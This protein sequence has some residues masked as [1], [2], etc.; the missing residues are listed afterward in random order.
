MH[1]W[2]G[3]QIPKC[4]WVKVRV[5]KIA[6]LQKR[7]S[8][9]MQFLAKQLIIG[10]SPI[11]LHLRR[12]KVWNSFWNMW[13]LP[14]DQQKG[15]WGG[16]RRKCESKMASKRENG[17]FLPP[18]VEAKSGQK[19]RYLK[20]KGPLG[21]KWKMAKMEGQGHTLGALVD[22]HCCWGWFVWGLSGMKSV[23]WLIWRNR[24]CF[25]GA[26]WKGLM[27]IKNEKGVAYAT[28]FVFLG[29]FASHIRR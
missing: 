26:L 24:W 5:V 20:I 7:A 9:L 1:G 2:A 23:W 21:S 12:P 10:F 13:H 15:G 18:A 19:Q 17:G 4:G 28:S 3:T 16:T 11:A 22:L 25:K 27:I 29:I 14:R 8:F 6:W